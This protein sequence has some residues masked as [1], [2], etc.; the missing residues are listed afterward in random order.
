M[1][2]ISDL[3]P[4]KRCLLMVYEICRTHRMTWRAKPRMRFFPS[5]SHSC[6]N[7]PYVAM[8]ARTAPQSGCTDAECFQK[9]THVI[10]TAWMAAN[11]RH[12]TLQ[13]EVPAGEKVSELVPL[14][15]SWSYSSEV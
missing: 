15:L 13:H 7:Q 1:E 6:R 5:E 3:G 4:E 9:T 10:L 11:S 2:N 12:N 14:E 8:S